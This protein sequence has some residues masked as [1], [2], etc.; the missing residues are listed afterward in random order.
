MPSHLPVSSRRR[1]HVRS[2]LDDIRDLIQRDVGAPGRIIQAPV[3]VFFQ[4]EFFSVS[5]S[6]T[7]IELS[8]E[9]KGCPGVVAGQ[10]AFSSPAVHVCISQ[11]NLKRHTNVTLQQFS[12]SA[13]ESI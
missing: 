4:P 5:H 2:L 8:L 12:A 11:G 10:E 3:P 6:Y 13:T 9:G 1:P 7:P